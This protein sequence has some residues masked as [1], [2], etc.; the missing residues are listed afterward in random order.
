MFQTLYFEDLALGM[1]ET[2]SKTVKNGDI[3]GFAEVS[4]D[5]NPIRFSA[6][7]ARKTQFGGR[8]VHGLLLRR[9]SFPGSSACGCHARGRSSS[10]RV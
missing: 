10:P 9:A 6:G 2:I 7:F 5:R 8:I 3:M 1:R 4:G